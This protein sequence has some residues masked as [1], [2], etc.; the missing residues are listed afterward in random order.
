MRPNS[1]KCQVRI[2]VPFG[3]PVRAAS[4]FDMS[5]GYQLVSVW[6]HRRKVIDSQ[7]SSTLRFDNASRYVGSVDERRHASSPLCSGSTR[8]RASC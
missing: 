5:T 7:P 1:V 6:C 8:A 2:I 3:T 4:T